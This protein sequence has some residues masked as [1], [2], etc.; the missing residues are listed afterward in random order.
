MVFCDLWSSWENITCNIGS[1][2][3]DSNTF[4]V[5]WH[6][7]VWEHKKHLGKKVGVLKGAKEYIGALDFIAKESILT[8]FPW[9]WMKIKR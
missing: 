7:C 1:K 8:D 6:H 2:E 4:S 9:K 5:G 3:L